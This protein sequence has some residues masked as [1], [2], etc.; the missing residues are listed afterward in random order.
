VKYDEF[1]KNKAGQM[2]EIDMDD[3][4]LVNYKKF[5]ELVEKI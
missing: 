1:L 5:A 3:G 4:F 2:I